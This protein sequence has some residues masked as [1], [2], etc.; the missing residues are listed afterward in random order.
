M[1]AYN[2]LSDVPVIINIRIFMR[3]GEV[4]SRLPSLK[5]EE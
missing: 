5:G 2:T 1:A 4:F 3:P